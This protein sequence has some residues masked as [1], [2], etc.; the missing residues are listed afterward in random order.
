M[1]PVTLLVVFGYI[2]FDDYKDYL[3]GNCDLLDLSAGMVLT[4]LVLM[5]TIWVCYGVYLTL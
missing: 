4:I 2:I 5:V 1:I 3:G